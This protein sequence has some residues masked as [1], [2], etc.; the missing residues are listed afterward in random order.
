MT[1]NDRK[2]YVRY[3]NKL[4]DQYNNTYHTLLVKKLVNAVITSIK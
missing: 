2:T 1:A 4:I 3:L